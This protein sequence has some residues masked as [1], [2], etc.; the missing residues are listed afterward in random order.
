MPSPRPPARLEV[1]KARPEA[2]SRIRSGSAQ[3]H[4]PTTE[5]AIGPIATQEGETA[6]TIVLVEVIT[7]VSC[8]TSTY[9][10]R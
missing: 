10:L 8:A 2:D 1:K 9:S 4:I 7:E 6:S 5:Q 3:A